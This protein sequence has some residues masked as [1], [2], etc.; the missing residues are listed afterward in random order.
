MEN[1][2]PNNMTNNTPV[3][4]SSQDTPDS[5]DFELSQYINLDRINPNKNYHLENGPKVLAS[6]SIKRTI[7]LLP[8]LVLIPASVHKP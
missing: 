2:T 5:K 1:N 7:L 8:L 3:N 4:L 6:Y